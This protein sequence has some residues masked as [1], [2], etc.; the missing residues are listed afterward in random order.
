MPLWQTQV[1]AEN[2]KRLM[3]GLTLAEVVK[4]AP[5]S[6]PEVFAGF[7]GGEGI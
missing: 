6:K 5:V 4:G 7:M 1:P 3:D 2:L